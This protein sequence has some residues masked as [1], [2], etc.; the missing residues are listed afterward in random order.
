MKLYV[1]DAIMDGKHLRGFTR[2]RAGTALKRKL[3]IDSLG[4]IVHW[5]NWAYY[6]ELRTTDYHPSAFIS[7][8]RD[9]EQN[10][11]A[12]CAAPT[13]FYVFDWNLINGNVRIYSKDKDLAEFSK[14]RNQ[15]QLS[16]DSELFKDVG[17]TFIGEVDI[18][19]KSTAQAM[20]IEDYDG[21][22]YRGFHLIF[23]RGATQKEFLE[24]A[25]MR[26]LKK[27]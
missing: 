11:L 16:A 27:N 5:K 22:I 18:E 7:I 17:E 13:K 21:L 15:L 19:S 20:G 2:N 9:V 12:A 24:R 10:G 4:I 6:G 8:I 3:Q 23:L 26:T 1:F 14:F 25:V